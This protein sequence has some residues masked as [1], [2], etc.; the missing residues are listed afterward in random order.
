[1][2]ITALQMAKTKPQPEPIPDG[3]SYLLDEKTG[4]WVDREATPA[5]CVMP[6]PETEPT[7]DPA[8]A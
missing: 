7:D 2:G 1:V 5:V 3:G 8:D 6:A 4:K